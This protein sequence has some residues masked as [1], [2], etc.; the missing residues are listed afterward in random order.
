MTL[1][2]TPTQKKWLMT[3]GTFFASG[4][5]DSLVTGLTAQTAWPVLI[6]SALVAGLVRVLG[7]GIAKT[8]TKRPAGE[9]RDL[10]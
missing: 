7:M 10:A 3:V 9:A 8:P 1:H 4:V 2:F 5:A 6:R